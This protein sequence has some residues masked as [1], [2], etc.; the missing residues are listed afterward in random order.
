MARPT[1]FGLMITAVIGYGASAHAA[2]EIVLA[3]GRIAGTVI[4]GYEAYLGIPYAA[5]PIGNL[6]WRPPQA[7]KPWSGVLDASDFGA[8]CPQPVMLGAAPDGPRMDEDCLSINVW[9]PPESAGK[10]L[11]VMVQIHGGAYFLGSS[12]KPLDQGITGLSRRGIVLVSMNYRL[13]RLGFFAHP[14]SAR[15]HPDEPTANYWLMDQIA[16]LEWVKRNIGHFGGDPENVTIFG[17]SA[18]GTSVNALVAS[19]KARGLFAKAIVQSGGGLFNSSTALADAHKVGLEVAAR[20][21]APGDDPTALAKLRSLTAE[22]ILGNEQGPP[23][24]GP[25]VDGTLLTA[26]IAESFAK[27]DIARVPYLSGSTSDE[28]SV[29]GLMGFTGE[30]LKEKFGIQLDT[31][32]PAYEPDGPLREDDLVSQVGTDFIFTAGSHGL[33]SMAA[34][35]GAPVYVYRLDYLGDEWRGTLTGVPHGGDQMY[36]FGVD[37]RPEGKASDGTYLAHPSDKDRRTAAM[38]QTYWTNFAKT[39]DPNGEALPAW[40]RYEGADPQTLVIDDDTAAAQDFRKAQLSVWYR[41]WEQQ[42]GLSVE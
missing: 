23:A 20:A 6:R 16:A 35:T 31:V 26:P 11:P 5:P 22:Q 7:V 13:G 41:M 17:V 42:T 40:P 24:Y 33:A 2:P 39:G 3:E 15:E 4:N 37:Y 36:V 28:F 8:V 14:A 38:I 21:G 30:T 18:G 25:V 10:K 34:R 9:S 12:R 32:R 19:P 1:L 29:F 27:G